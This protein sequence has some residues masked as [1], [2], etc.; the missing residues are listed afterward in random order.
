MEEWLWRLRIAAIECNYKEI[1]RQLKEHF[2]H[3]LNDNSIEVKVIKEI[4]KTE[5]NKD[6]TINEV[7]QWAR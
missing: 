4:S 3:G 2:I 1:G 6:V 5:E 7:L